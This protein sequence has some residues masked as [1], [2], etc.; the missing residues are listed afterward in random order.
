[1]TDIMRLFR[2]V[3]SLAGRKLWPA[4]SPNKTW[5]GAL[6]G[7][8]GAVVAGFG[9]A[10]FGALPL[11]HRLSLCCGYCRYVAQ[12]GD[13]FE[14]AFKRQFGA[15]DASHL[16]P[17]HGGVMDRLDGFSP[18]RWRHRHRLAARRRDAPPRGL[19]VW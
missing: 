5:S 6:G 10:T 14:S 4:I 19:L 13:L 18:R 9:V 8:A 11:A 15:K 1:M 16:I 2:W 12:A 17:G 7:L 3:A